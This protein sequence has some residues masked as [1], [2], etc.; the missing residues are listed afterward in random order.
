MKMEAKGHPYLDGYQAGIKEVVEEI[1]DLLDSGKFSKP[2]W[3]ALKDK[4]GVKARC[5]IC[6]REG[7]IGKCA[8][9]HFACQEHA[10]FHRERNK[11]IP[12]CINCYEKAKLDIESNPQEMEH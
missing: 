8:C 1:E 12:M 3:Q 2:A 11:L 10:Y 7:D 5:S 9:G 6:D 4:L